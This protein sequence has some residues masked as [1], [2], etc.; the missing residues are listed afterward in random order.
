MAEAKGEEVE[1]AA[2]ASSGPPLSPV[3]NLPLSPK[4]PPELPATLRASHGAAITEVEPDSLR[5]LD[6]YH[7]HQAQ[8]AADFTTLMKNMFLRLQKLEDLMGEPET[9]PV[10]GVKAWWWL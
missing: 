5:M 2:G 9:N 7:S 4:P 10:R 1:G 6:A 3:P 8:R